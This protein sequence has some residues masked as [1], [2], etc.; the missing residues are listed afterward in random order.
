MAR[1]LQ[2][3]VYKFDELDASTQERVISNW[4]DGDQFFWTDE[5]AQSLDA[6]AKLAPLT[7]RNWDIGYRGNGVTFDM[8]QDAD[9]GNG[10]A[11]L[12]GVRAWKWLVN[13][14]WAELAAGQS[15]PFTGY[16]GD[17][18]LLDAIRAALANPASITSLRDVFADAL[19]GWA[20]AFEADVD[21]WQSEEAIRED[22][23]ANEYEFYANGT[24]V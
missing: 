4:R 11:E 15:C 17:E 5:W 12:S 21:H 22:I 8:D 6:F 23:E 19:H 1:A 13:N 10:I 3:T 14:G 7:V 16:C 18:D 2:I 24:I 20:S 9:Y